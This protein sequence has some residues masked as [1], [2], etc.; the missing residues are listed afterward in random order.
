MHTWPKSNQ[1][2]ILLNYNAGKQG[3]TNLEPLVAGYIFSH[4]WM[5]QYLKG[6]KELS[7]FFLDN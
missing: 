3:T 4:I 1:F 7:S 2:K 6:E 5:L